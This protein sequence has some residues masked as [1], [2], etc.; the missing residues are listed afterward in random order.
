MPCFN[1]PER[2]REQIGGEPTARD[3]V[4]E[5]SQ[6]LKP[7]EPQRGPDRSI[8]ELIARPEELHGQQVR[9][10]GY[11]TL[12][13]EGTAIYLSAHDAQH[14][15]SKNGIWLSVPSDDW[16]EWD[17]CHAKYALVEGTYNA[18][19]LGHMDAFSGTIEQIVRLEPWPVFLSFEVTKH[20]PA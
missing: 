19:A 17:K 1:R 11:V 6:H 18:K 10:I 14:G 15:I 5:I 4:E 20:D 13:I 7:Y 16:K 12:L 9:V 3:F 2:E 8:I